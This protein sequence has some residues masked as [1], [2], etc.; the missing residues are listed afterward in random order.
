V[1]QVRDCPRGVQFRSALRRSGIGFDQRAE[2]V[3]SSGGLTGSRHIAGCDQQSVGIIERRLGCRIGA[4]DRFGLGEP[5]IGL[6]Q[7]DQ[8]GLAILIA[9]REQRRLASGR[10][11]PV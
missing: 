10:G 4:E 9:H 6:V 1:R 11:V 2:C 5:A 7:I 8:P 3:Q